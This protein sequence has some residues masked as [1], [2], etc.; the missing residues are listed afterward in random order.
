[1]SDEWLAQH[2]ALKA[3]YHDDGHATADEACECYKRY[4]LD[5]ALRFSTEQSTKRQCEVCKEWT[6]SH[7]TVGGYTVFVLCEAHAN[8]AEVEKL[9]S[10]GESWE[11]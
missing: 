9:F 2:L 3:N 1:M 6:Q 4:E 10:V 5:T 11:S 7:A 8:R